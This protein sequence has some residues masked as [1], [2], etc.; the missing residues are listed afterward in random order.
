MAL[1]VG[2]LLGRYQCCKLF[3]NSVQGMKCCDE[4]ETLQCAPRLCSCNVLV[5]WPDEVVEDASAIC[6]KSLREI[7]ARPT[8]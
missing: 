7:N 2:G 6:G 5:S 8:S 1:F 3:R 4:L